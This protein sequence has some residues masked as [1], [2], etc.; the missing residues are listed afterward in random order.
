MDETLSREHKMVLDAVRYWLKKQ[1]PRTEAMAWDESGQ[2]PPATL[3]SFMELDLWA[4]GVDEAYGGTGRDWLGAGVV[5]ETLAEMDP[6][7]AG[8]YASDVFG[9]AAV[10]AEI[11]NDHQK[12]IWL[13]QLA[14]GKL[15]TAR[16]KPNRE[17]AEIIR[18]HPGERGWILNGSARQVANAR[19]AQ[20]LV[21]EAVSDIAPETNSFFLV[22]TTDKGLTITPSETLGYR[23]AGIGSVAF[24]DTFLPPEALLGKPVT[25]SVSTKAAARIH[26][27]ADLATAA[28][29]VGIAQGA[30]D[31]ALAHARSR[32]QFNQPIG[33]FPAL[34]E[35]LVDLSTAIRAARLMM[36]A[37][38]S[39]ANASRK[40]ETEAAQA[41][42]MASATAEKAAL[43]GIQILGGYGYTLEYD[44]QRYLRNAM[45][46]VCS[47]TETSALN[48]TIGRTLGVAP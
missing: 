39:R 38:A 48:E 1:C 20:L 11:G 34:R 6:V 13:P 26:G 35:K 9:A 31:Y 7:L 18:F 46:L 47:A 15:A 28:Q 30:L 45:Q 23:S 44:A 24:K 40:F 33:R 2:L 25:G 43:D 14:E 8:I 19:R 22:S 10:I 37:A 27:F 36:H 29:A 3:E 21:V 42:L 32:V 16:V 17:V 41:L 5:V 4:M 12:S